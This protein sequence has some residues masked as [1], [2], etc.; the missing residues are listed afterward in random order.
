M[1]LWPAALAAG[2]LAVV[3]AAHA[4]GDSSWWSSLRM[5][6]SGASCCDI[7][8]CAY[9]SARFRDGHWQAVVAGMWRDIDPTRILDEVSPDGRAVVCAG[10]FGPEPPI[11]CFIPESSGS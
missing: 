9:T 6:G 4:G 2:M 1:R 7:S 10:Q 5:P 11:Y 8:D 3:P